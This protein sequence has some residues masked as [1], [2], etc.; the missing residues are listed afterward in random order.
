MLSLAAATPMP[1]VLGSY[2]HVDCGGCLHAPAAH[3]CTTTS[4]QACSALQKVYP[5]TPTTNACWHV[6]LLYEWLC[7][8]VA[9]QTWQQP[10]WSCGAHDGVF[11]QLQALIPR[12]I[13]DDT[14][15][16]GAPHSSSDGGVGA[17]S[18]KASGG[19]SGSSSNKVLRKTWFIRLRPSKPPS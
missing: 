12:P 13:D 10:S 6:H 16:Q 15:D 18:N 1:Q 4:L 11:V 2:W 17:D 8:F 3:V 14:T 19:S 5:H 7:A 9:M